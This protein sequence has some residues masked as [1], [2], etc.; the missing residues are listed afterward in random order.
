MPKSGGAPVT[1]AVNQVDPWSI[2][3]DVTHVH[4]ANRGKASLNDAALAKIWH[5]DRLPPS[6][7]V[8]CG[9]GG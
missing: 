6:R 5:S 4:W 1:L 2:A 8:R 9:F 7:E 3:V